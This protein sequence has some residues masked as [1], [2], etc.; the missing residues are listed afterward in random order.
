[1]V[2]QQAPSLADQVYDA[3]VDEICDGHL[4]AGMHLG[5]EQIA[6]RF[7]VSRQPIQQ[8]MARLDRT[9]MRQ[10]YGMRAAGR[11]EVEPEFAAAVTR[12]GRT[13]LEASN[14]VAAAGAIAEQ[15]QLDEAL[16]QMIYALSGNPMISTAA[17]SH[18]R[19]LRR[20]MGEVLRQTDLPG[21]IWPDHAAIAD[22]EAAA[23]PA[24]SGGRHG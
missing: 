3:I 8:A 15:I 17:A 4:A 13:I 19:F 16:H 24:V 7:G 2:L 14:A 9:W 5:Q 22:G 21:T 1:M 10:L 6:A 18:W 12:E 20:A 11:A 23:P